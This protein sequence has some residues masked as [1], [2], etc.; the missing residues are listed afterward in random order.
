MA[1]R[2]GA[3]ELDS[4]QA[5]TGGR[6][7]RVREAVLS[8]VR[9]E[10]MEDGYAGLSHIA[11]GRR[12][13]VDPATVYRRW[14][15]R[16]RL[17]VDAI[18]ELAENAVPLP[19]TGRLGTDL[20]A[21]HKSVTL[22]LAEERT[23]RLFQA[24]SAATF[25]QDPDVAKALRA[26]WRRRISAATVIFDRAA[27]RGEINSPRNPGELIEQLVAPIYFRA[28]VTRAPLDRRLTDRSVERVLSV[29]VA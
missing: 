24:F 15:S 11:V 27:A 23:L 29:L 9:E 4:V 12:A 26:F 22:L 18:I 5:R 10:L 13:G 17:A 19:D 25:E 7:A 6:S 1:G 28:L 14:P 21:L 8:A 2:A 3:I 16:S 20:K